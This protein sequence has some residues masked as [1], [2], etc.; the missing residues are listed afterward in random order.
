MQWDFMTVF[1]MIGA[2]SY[3]HW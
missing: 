2:F 3:I 1:E